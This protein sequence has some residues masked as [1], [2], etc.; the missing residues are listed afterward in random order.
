LIM[1]AFIPEDIVEKIKADTDILE[2][3]NEFVTL[4]KAGKDYVGLCPFHREKTPSFTVVPAKEFFYCFGCGASGN[5]VN[6]IMRH[7]NLEYPEA[8]RF[9]AKRAGIA[10]P[11]SIKAESKTGEIYRAVEFAQ[12]YFVGQLKNSPAYEYIKSRG[13]SDG[14]IAEF[15][16]GFAPAGWDNLY[17]RIKSEKLPVDIFERAGL[18][19]RK[20]RSDETAQVGM[21]GYYDK[22]RNR[23][24]FPI[25]NVAGRIV[26]FGGRALSD[27]EG[28]K[29]L[30]S[31]ETAIYHKGSILYGLNQAKHHIREAGR[32]IITEG[33]FDYI[34]LYQA[35]IKNV[36]AVSGTGFTPDQAALL[37][38]FGGEVVLLY[39]ADSA[40]LKATFRAID[41]IFNAGL[42]PLIARLPADF[43]PDSFVRQKGVVEM[44]RLIDSA[45]GYLEFIR[46]SLPDHFGKLPISQQQKVISSMAE[47]A[48]KISDELKLELFI[49]K[50]AEIFDLPA[51]VMTGFHRPKPGAAIRKAPK[52]IGRAD[53]EKQFLG[54]LLA[55]PEFIEECA[56]SVK[57]ENFI[58]PSNREIYRKLCKVDGAAFKIGDF[59]EQFIDDNARTRLTEI[60]VNE[61]G[62]APPDILFTAFVQKF[63]NLQVSDRLS[64]IRS[65]IAQAER[66]GDFKAVERLSREFHDL[67]IAANRKV[68]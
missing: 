37:A 60:I 31:P 22:F 18:L 21:S 44:R 50:V 28:P 56:I 51:K 3:I 14:T 45:L 23:L 25:A 54:F 67:Q 9:L 41:V 2:L 10:I 5:A 48:Q 30:N 38:R 39:D 26:G 33:Y 27:E 17:K 40:G 66:E 47:I 53:F 20:D 68:V 24:I 13:I 61:A 57:S 65:E 58:E 59:L 55:N 29:Y 12:N 49:R 32:A 4:K 43:D 52:M 35:G 8:L 42:E 46:D 1:P 62:G 16:I 11:E 15:G 36:V 34:S 64:Q 19:V 6:F 63:K 7:E